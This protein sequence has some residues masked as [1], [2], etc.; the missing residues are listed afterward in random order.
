MFTPYWRHCLTLPVTEP[1]RAP[2]GTIPA[3]ALW[4]GSLALAELS[5]L[6]R[7]RWDAGIAAATAAGAFAAG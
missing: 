6:P 5:L 3:P 7:I 2:A 4:P 1:G